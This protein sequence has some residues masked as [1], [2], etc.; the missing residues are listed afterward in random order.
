MGTFLKPISVLMGLAAGMLFGVAT[1][2]SKVLLKQLNSFQLAGLLYLGAALASLPYV[3]KHHKKEIQWIKTTDRKRAIVGIV[4]F[5][6]LLGP[7]F[8]LVGLN[9]AASSSVSIW[10][11][12]ELVATAIL[13][14]IFF[15]DHLDKPAIIG[16][17]LTFAAGVIVT[18]QDGF[19]NL[20]P[21]I[22]VT[23]ACFSWGIDNHLTAIVDSASPKM[24]TFIKGL[25]AGSTNL[26]I[27]S[28][29]AGKGYPLQFL[30]VALLVGIVSYGLSIILYVT[31]AQQLGATR[32]QIL[33][34]TGP[35]WGILV[36]FIV[37]GE[38]VSAFSIAAVV[39][40]ALGIL[41]TNLLVHDHWHSHYAVTHVHPHYHDDGHHDH[42]HADGLQASVLHS[43]LHTHAEVSHTHK[44]YPD[45]HHRH[46]HGANG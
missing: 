18:I 10:L 36:A 19:G 1:P 14:V 4:I 6:G 12:M 34:S 5:G 9:L 32:S 21:A 31:S 45:L 41:F 27:G 28:I 3:L 2:I 11:N 29:I 23:L 26:L 8:L 37:L 38:P 30:G 16:V 13:G 35:F 17:L 39:L 44:H 25:F 42:E 22:F 33:F 43:H 24:I 15:K 46:A 7:L 40:L 20:V